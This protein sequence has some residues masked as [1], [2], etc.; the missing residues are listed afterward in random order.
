MGK[1]FVV[2][3]S[4]S[5][6]VYWDTTLE[7]LTSNQVSDFAP[8]VFFRIH[9][10]S[11]TNSHCDNRIVKRDSCHGKTLL[12]M[13]GLVGQQARR[14]RLVCSASSHRGRSRRQQYIR[15]I[16]DGFKQVGKGENRSGQTTVNSIT[17]E[18]LPPRVNSVE[19]SVYDAT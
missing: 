12:V 18:T 9:L 5:R 4:C 11:S 2:S 14:D 17:Q 16:T 15:N 3:T 7:G 10:L 1:I 13:V 19:F 6:P 8:Q